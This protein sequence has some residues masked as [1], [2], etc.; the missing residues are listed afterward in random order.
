MF[1]G[2]NNQ[3]IDEADVPI[4]ATENETKKLDDNVA[5]NKN[6]DFDDSVQNERKPTIPQNVPE[7]IEYLYDFTFSERYDEDVSRDFS[8]SLNEITLSLYEEYQNKANPQ[9]QLQYDGDGMVPHQYKRYWYEVEDGDL[10]VGTHYYE[11][12]NL[13]YL[14]YLW[15]DIEG[16]KTD[17]GISVGDSVNKLLGAYKDNLF[18][19]EKGEARPELLVIDD[20]L[21]W[22]S[23][24]GA[25]VWQPYS[26][27][28][29][30]TRDITFYVENQIV[31]AIE[32]VQPF[33]LRYV[34]RN[35]QSEFTY[36]GNAVI[37]S[38]TTTTEIITK[39]N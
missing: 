14:T 18:F 5:G 38:E 10:V 7:G 3:I 37:G 33:E 23:Y 4:N 6:N 19:I 8:L 11:P 9:M 36:L 34:Y 26:P 32:M 28:R 2:C 31:T 22:A 24:D 16:A 35:N 30:D 17:N 27:E 1:V 29:R 13:E 39:T 21:Q 25:Y 15:T 20:T 12:D